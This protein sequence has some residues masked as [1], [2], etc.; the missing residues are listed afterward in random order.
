MLKREVWNN[1][2]T[3]PW[4]GLRLPLFALAIMLIASSVGEL[5]KT[6]GQSTS[7]CNGTYR[8]TT[9]WNVGFQGDVTVINNGPAINGWTVT[10]MFPTTTQTI[11]RV[12]ERRLYAV[13]PECDGQ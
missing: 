4:R 12:M 9:F 11:Y 10:F 2:F 13:G 3:P 6:Q 5:K 1:V 7:P 8:E